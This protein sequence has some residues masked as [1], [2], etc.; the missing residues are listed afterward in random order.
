MP[1][2]DLAMSD[3]V[4]IECPGCGAREDADPVL[5]SETRRIVCRNCG[6]TWPAAPERRKRR[7]AAGA[8]APIHDPELLQAE[9]RPLVTYSG[10]PDKAWA[11]KVEGDVWPAPPQRSRIPMLAAALAATVFIGAFFSAREA[12][13]AAL[14]DLAGL[15]AALGLP[16]SLDALVIEDL[17]AERT[18]GTDGGRLTLRGTVRNVSAAEQPAPALT[19]SVEDSAMTTLG[20]RSF[21]PPARMMAVG[22]AAPFL[23]E[24][25]GVPRQGARIVVRFRRPA[26]PVASA[27]EGSTA[28]P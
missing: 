19:A 5:L 8:E 9:R 12:A 6:D 7:G 14:P 21:D 24:L 18:P 11:A 2:S 23:L 3:Y 10:G 22:E 16:V 20:R 13:V 26:E 15:Y 28:A 1:Q 25:D 17:A 4:V 27:G